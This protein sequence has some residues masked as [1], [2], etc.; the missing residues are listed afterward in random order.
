MMAVASS[1][2][3]IVVL[4]CAEMF[5]VSCTWFFGWLGPLLRVEQCSNKHLMYTKKPLH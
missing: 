1:V 2:K 3:S 5:M 4:R